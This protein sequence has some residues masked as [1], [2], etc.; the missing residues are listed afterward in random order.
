MKPITSHSEYIEF[1][2]SVYDNP[3]C[4]SI[5]EFES[6]LRRFSIFGRLVEKEERQTRL[7][8]NTVVILF[9]MFGN[10]TLALAQYKLSPESYAVFESIAKA[11]N[12]E[13][14]EIPEEHSWITKEFV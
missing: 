4:M 1:A 7:I 8:I 6:D 10:G 14:G 3:A 13:F 9:N 2:R 12:R 5:A 11:L